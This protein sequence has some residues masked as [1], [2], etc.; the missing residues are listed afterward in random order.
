MRG[1]INIVQLKDL[2][3]YFLASTVNSASMLSPSSAYACVAATCRPIL[4]SRLLPIL[5]H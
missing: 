4:A 3:W 1:S 5:K 2:I